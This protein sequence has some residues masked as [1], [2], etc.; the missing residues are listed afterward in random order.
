V[1]SNSHDSEQGVAAAPAPAA[2][3]AAAAA[4]AA[5]ESA[6]PRTH[7]GTQDEEAAAV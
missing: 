7:H 3:V 2:E 4:A 1:Q 6:K 5:A